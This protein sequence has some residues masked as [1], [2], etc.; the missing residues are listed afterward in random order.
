M[1]CG[2]IVV[3][4]VVVVSIGIFTNVCV[5]VVVC[6]VFA[7]GFGGFRFHVFCFFAA[8]TGNV[9]STLSSILHLW[10]DN[11][12][13]GYFFER[14]SGQNNLDAPHTSLQ[15]ATQVKRLTPLYTR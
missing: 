11:T 2:G 12:S 1:F 9:V 4:V 13:I 8:V 14:F 3:V 7:A 6:H 10:F 15:P 5:T